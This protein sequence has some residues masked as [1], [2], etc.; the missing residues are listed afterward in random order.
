MAPALPYAGE[1]VRFQCSSDGGVEGGREEGQGGAE[2]QRWRRG[3]E[4]TKRE[5]QRRGAGETRAAAARALGAS[6]KTSRGFAK[7]E[8]VSNFLFFMSE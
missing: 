6:C 5:G 1:V 4:S 8:Q 3:E 2:V 7:K